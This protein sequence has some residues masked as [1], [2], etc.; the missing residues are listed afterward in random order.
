MISLF[1]SR[2]RFSG[3][4]SRCAMPVECMYSAARSIWRIEPQ[5]CRHSL[6]LSVH[7]YGFYFALPILVLWRCCVD[8]AL[9]GFVRL[10][11]AAIH[12]RAVR[13]HR[14][15]SCGAERG[16]SC[17]N[18]FPLSRPTLHH[19]NYQTGVPKDACTYAHGSSVVQVLRSEN[20]RRI[21]EDSLGLHDAFNSAW[22]QV[23]CDNPT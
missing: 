22:L 17:A 14:L 1:S 7:H 19:I 18:S 2:R 16:S 5:L 21:R 15:H 12:N 13:T 10:M 11:R 8:H 4:R 3:L 23:P 9:R 20:I 6:I